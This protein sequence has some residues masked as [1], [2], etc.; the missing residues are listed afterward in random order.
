MSRILLAISAVILS[1]SVLIHAVSTASAY[2]SGPEVTGGEAPWV[3][4]SGSTNPHS[5]KELY[6]VPD[7]RILVLTGAILNSY[8]VHLYQDGVLKVNGYSR[9]MNA[10]EGGMLSQGNGRI[11]FDPGT[12]VILHSD[13]ST[14]YYSL[15]GY[16]AHP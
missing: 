9:A 6:T 1:V 14:R 5:T 8:D 3:S 13:G 4:M 15:Q 10:D 7:D 2:P 11:V 12:N 16:L